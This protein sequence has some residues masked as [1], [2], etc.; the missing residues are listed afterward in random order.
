METLSFELPSLIRFANKIY[1]SACVIDQPAHPRSL[2]RVFDGRSMDSKGS[3]KV[4]SCLKLAP[5]SDCADVQTDL[6]IRY[7]LVL[8]CQLVLYAGYQLY[9]TAGLWKDT[10]DHRW[11]IR[12]ILDRKVIK[13]NIK[14]QGANATCIFMP[15][16]TGMIASKKSNIL[17]RTLNNK[18]RAFQFVY[19]M[20][21]GDAV[22]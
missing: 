8:T 12:H 10:L 20:F 14:R 4:S 6:N 19:N 9:W 18:N 2:I 7:T 5:W 22:Y 11:M 21:P 16:C 3:F 17:R 1:K 13:L 15:T